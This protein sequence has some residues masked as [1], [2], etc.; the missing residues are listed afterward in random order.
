MITDAQ[1]QQWLAT[2]GHNR[3]VLIELDHSAGTEY[4]ADRRHIAR[5][6]NG[7]R[8]I[9]EGALVSEL[10][11]EQR[12]DNQVTP[13]DLDI[14]NAGYRDSW[15]NKRW[16][17]YEIRYLLGD[18]SWSI[19]DFRVVQRAINAG[20]SS[21]DA[22]QIRFSITDSHTVF[23]KPVAVGTLPDGQPNPLSLGEPFNVPAIS[24]NSSTHAFRVNDGAITDAVAR[25]NGSAVSVTADFSNG[26]FQL[27]SA[28][29]GNLCA[30]ITEQHVTAAQII[31]WVAQQYGVA[32]NATNLAL[33][34][35][36]SI[37]LHYSGE[38]TGRQILDDVAASIGGYW[39]RNAIG[40][41]ECYQLTAPGVPQFTLMPGEI[42][43]RGIT[44]LRREPPIKQLTLNYKRNFSTADR[45]SLAG[46]LE[47]NAALTELLTSEWRTTTISNTL[48][49]YPS[50]E[51]I[52]RDTYL[53]NQ[54]DAAAECQRRAGLKSI[55]RSVWGIECGLAPGQI[56]VGQTIRVKYPMFGFESG[57]DLRVISMTP[58]WSQNRVTIEGWG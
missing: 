4:I 22:E 7:P 15:L 44:L 3:R 34:P 24:I 9:Y 27:A 14:V 39:R 21:I 6:A 17:G 54:A 31:T 30:D 23:D 35:D 53:V 25:V 29:L 46:I 43:D 28:P 8:R 33:L 37:G 5:P 2:D 58:Q 32:V 16:A 20:V 26:G 49:G 48:A 10:A 52:S 18:I 11:I 38:V 12:L 50:A 1:F 36:Y 56:H 51:T 45:D 41:L 57:K 13:G 55:E 42:V 19:S 40:E 47:N